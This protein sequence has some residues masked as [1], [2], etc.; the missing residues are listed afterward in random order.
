MKGFIVGNGVTN[1]AYDSNSYL[2]FAAMHGLFSPHI[3]KELKEN[4]CYVKKTSTK[5]TKL[6]ALAREVFIIISFF[7]LFICLFVYLFICLFVSLF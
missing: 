1:E 2:P 6:K 7:W 3:A 5:C 4:D